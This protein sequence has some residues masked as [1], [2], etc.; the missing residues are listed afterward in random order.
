[1]YYTECKPKNQKW[2]RPGNEAKCSNLFLLYTFHVAVASDFSL[3]TDEKI[4]YPPSI[5]DS[6]ITLNL[7]F[8]FFFLAYLFLASSSF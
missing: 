6:D 5:V 1:M 4:K 8:F 7:F 3:Y 2:G